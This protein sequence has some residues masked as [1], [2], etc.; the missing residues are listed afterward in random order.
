VRRLAIFM[1]V[2]R[3]E[4][5]CRSELLLHRCEASVVE[6]SISTYQKAC[7]DAP[8]VDEY[9]CGGPIRS[10]ACGNA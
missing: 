2:T 4:T 5:A 8:P 7:I 9:Y 6:E 1:S 3:T 10:F